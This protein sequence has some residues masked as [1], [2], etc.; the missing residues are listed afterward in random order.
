MIYY[1]RKW[2]KKDLDSQILKQEAVNLQNT[3]E[4]VQSISKIAILNGSPGKFNWNSEIFEILEIE[5]TDG[6]IDYNLLLKYATQDSVDL[7][8]EKWESAKDAGLGDVINF[9]TTLTITTG[10]G[11]RKYLK[12][13]S[14]NYIE[15]DF[16]SRVINAFVEDITDEIV[17][18]KN[19]EKS[20]E[21]QKILIKE[22][23]HRVKNNLQ[24][25][26]SF[27]SLEKRFHPGDYETIL[28]V[29]EK[30]INSLS[31]IHTRIYNQDDMNYILMHPFLN[32]LDDALME[33][34][35]YTDI[36]FNSD[37]PEYLA[38]AIDTVTPLTFNY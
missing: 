31:S 27:I 36:N 30:R 21:N 12:Y 7:V 8:Y 3:I 24:L 9:E 33:F 35:P 19:L 10:K 14:S 16:E 6:L 18:Q 29:T 34:S 23:H 37:V 22:V 13:F 20:L 17:A 4:N 28:N 25:I 26:R 5:P 32:E 2:V 11:T 38:F 15:T 1:S